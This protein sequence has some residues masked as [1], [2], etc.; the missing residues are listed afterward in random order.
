MPFVEYKDFDK[1]P[2]DALKDDFDTKFALKVKSQ[3]PYGVSVTS[4]TEYSPGTAAFPGK[5]NLKWA[6]DKFSVDKLEV[7]SC[8]KITLESSLALAPGLNLEFKGVDKSAGTLGAVYKHQYA[9]IASDLDIAAF[10]T[11]KASVLGG[12]HGVVGGAS[13]NFALGNKFEV[14][15]YSAALGYTPC[16]GVFAGVKATNKLSEFNGA[17]QCKIKPNLAAS[18]LVDFVPKTSE[19]KATVGVAY[20]CNEKTHLKLKLNNLGAVSVSVKQQFPNSLSV[21]GAAGV[22]VKK[23]ESYSFGVTATLG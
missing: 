7:S 4:T 2:R 3:A 13:A 8:D 14:R 12:A 22:D 17:L 20:R 23:L 18:A 1:V 21:V 15:D 16:E 10:S 5:V 6:H 19:V 9:T 11:L